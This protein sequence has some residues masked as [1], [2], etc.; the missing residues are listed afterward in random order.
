MP[1]LNSIYTSACSTVQR[2]AD[3]ADQSVFEIPNLQNK[4]P[5]Q[6]V[7]C[8]ADFYGIQYPFQR[9]YMSHG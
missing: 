7:K 3:M 1:Q 8:I 4:K 2:P 6:Q 5:L 9:F